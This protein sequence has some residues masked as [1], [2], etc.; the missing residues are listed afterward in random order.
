MAAVAQKIRDTGYEPG[1]WTC[2]FVIMADSPM[3]KEHPELAAKD[4]EGNRV[5]FR[6]REAPAYALDPTCPFAEDYLNELFQRLKKWGYN[7]H[8]LDFLRSVEQDESIRFYDRSCTR[9]E[10]Y[11]RGMSIIKEAVGKDGYVIACGGLFE[12]SAGLVDSVRSGSDVKGQWYDNPE[13]TSSYLHRIKQ[14]VYR[15]VYNHLWHTDPDALMLRLADKPWKHSQKG[16]EDLSVGN[17][18]DEEAFTTVVNQFLGDGLICFSE[19]LK[20]VQKERLAMLRHVI[21]V[22]ESKTIPLD[23]ENQ[24]CPSVFVTK[25]KPSCNTLGN[26]LILTI[27]NW[28]DTDIEKTVE[29]SSLDAF[30]VGSQMAVF[31]F[32][33]QC[34]YGIQKAADS[35][36]IRIP[37]HGTRVFRLTEITDQ[38]PK[39]IGTDLHL[40]AG[41]Q[42]ITH[43]AAEN[44]TIICKLVSP[45]NCQVTVTALFH[46]D[47][48]VVVTHQAASNSTFTLHCPAPAEIDL[49]D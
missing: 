33:E 36:N 25:V 44:G 40:T 7:Y 49:V 47:N 12:A 34:F 4:F 16:Y 1:I 15:N 32:Y 19:R 20:T 24:G 41:C 27:A 38:Q 29:L 18:T 45:W 6:Y 21:P 26:S 30:G 39:I 42:E 46:P 11:V 17:L 22:V 9:A 2:P 10:A 8:K 37:A 43:V 35:I 3:L 14:N 23:I 5:L 31:E 13:K 48:P 28:E